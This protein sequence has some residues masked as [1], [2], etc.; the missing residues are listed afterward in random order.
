MTLFKL[1]FLRRSQI[2]DI[3]T[4]QL[5]RK[6]PLGL[7]KAVL[8]MRGVIEDPALAAAVSAAAEHELGHTPAADLDFDDEPTDDSPDISGD[9]I[10]D[11]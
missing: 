1:D 2:A 7:A 10:A 6:G 5:E 8:T 4:N 11:L 3:M 9:E